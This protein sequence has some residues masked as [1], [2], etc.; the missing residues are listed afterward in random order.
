L[1]DLRSELGLAGRVTFAGFRSNPYPLMRNAHLFVL[2]SSWEGFPLVLIEALALG[3]PVV[4]TDCPSGPDELLVDDHLGYL[5][6][7]DQPGCLAD[8]I[9]R[10]LET[11]DS[12]EDRTSRQ[13][14]ARHYSH[15]R[16]GRRYLQELPG[17]G[18]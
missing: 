2:S 9:L 13:R 18:P 7:P 10:S 5:V 4:S 16:I 15:R 3:S 8:R 17:N 11:T 14:H 6:P 1:R 12:N